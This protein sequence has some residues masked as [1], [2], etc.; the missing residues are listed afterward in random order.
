[1]T[2]WSLAMGIVSRVVVLARYTRR[3]TRT[4]GSYPLGTLK[5][6]DSLF[7][8]CCASHTV[9]RTYNH[10]SQSVRSVRRSADSALSIGRTGTRTGTVFRVPDFDDVMGDVTPSKS[11]L[12]KQRLTY[13]PA[14]ANGG[15]RRAGT[16]TPQSA[17]KAGTPSPGAGTPLSERRVAREVS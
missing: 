3:D 15:V 11:P 2:S 17:K 10:C 4:S 8:P 9:R 5:S 12:P 16:A 6:W 13:S 1:M 14:S 7:G